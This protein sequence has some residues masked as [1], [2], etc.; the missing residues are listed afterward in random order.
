MYSGLIYRS[1]FNYTVLDLG[2]QWY[3]PTNGYLIPFNQNTFI[4]TNGNFYLG[5]YP[6]YFMGFRF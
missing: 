3:G 4:V 6:G 1:P 2:P 5:P